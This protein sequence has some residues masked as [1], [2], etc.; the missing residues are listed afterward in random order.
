MSFAN[1]L[2]IN[3]DASSVRNYEL[4]SWVGNK[5]IRKDSTIGT[6]QP[7]YLTVSHS[8][9]KE[10][11]IL[12]DRHLARFDRTV[13]DSEEQPTTGSFYIVAVMPKKGFS[14][15]QMQDLVT[16]AKN[17]LSSTNVARLLNSEP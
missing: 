1:T 6:D 5:T 12:V 7:F 8:E 15:A 14:A 2:T 13:I 3:G 17:F 4:T 11:G 10:A 16:Q 9:S